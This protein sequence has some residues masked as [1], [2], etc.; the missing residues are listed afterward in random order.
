[1]DYVSNILANI[2]VLMN[3]SVLMNC[4]H[5][6]SQSI[7]SRF[8]VRDKIQSRW[9]VSRFN[10]TR[11]HLTNLKPVEP[12]TLYA[13]GRPRVTIICHRGN[14]CATPATGR[15]DPENLFPEM[16]VLQGLRTAVP[17]LNFL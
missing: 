15:A 2:L 6:H 5:A 17:K 4:V 14:P 13:E 7:L 12:P 9:K 11:S 10:T 16:P 1:M 3:G 8:I